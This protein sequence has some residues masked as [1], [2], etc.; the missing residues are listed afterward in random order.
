MRETHLAED[1]LATTCVL[2]SDPISVIKIR[3][4]AAVEEDEET[5]R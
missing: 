1:A 3:S 4:A 2:I 5:E